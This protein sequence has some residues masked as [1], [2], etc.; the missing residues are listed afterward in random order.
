MK[1]TIDRVFIV[2]GASVNGAHGRGRSECEMSVVKS[3]SSFTIIYSNVNNTGDNKLTT[4]VTSSV[5]CRELGLDCHPSVRPGDVGSLLASTFCTTG[6]IMRHEDHRRRRGSNVKAAYMTTVITSNLTRV[7]DINSSETCV[8]S[9]SN[10]ERVA[11]SRA[12]I[13]C[14]RSGNVVGRRRVGARQVGGLVAHT[15][16]VSRGLSMSC[17]RISV[18]RDSVLLV[19]ASKL[20]GCYSSRLVCDVI[21]GR[22]L[23]RTANRLVSCTGTQNNGSG[24]AIILVST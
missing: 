4:S 12:I 1:G 6:D 20:A 21:C 22:P 8:L 17:F 7:T 5:M 24:V 16:N 18:D 9:R 11:G 3:S 13:R 19:Y 10:V 2:K 14:L 15:V 23:R